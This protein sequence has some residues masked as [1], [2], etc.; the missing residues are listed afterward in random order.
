MRTLYSPEQIAEAI[1]ADE[2]IDDWKPW[3]PL[4]GPQSRCIVT[5]ADETFYGGQAGGSKTNTL[6][7]LALYHHRRSTIFRKTFL[8]LD[9]IIDQIRS[10]GGPSVKVS[11]TK[12]RAVTADG[13]VI[14]LGYMQHEKDKQKYKGRPSDF[15]GIDEAPDFTQSQVDFVTSWV[16]TTNP[17][18][19]TRV[20]LT[21]NPPTTLEGLW[22]I[23]AFAPWLKE[24][25]PDPAEPGELRWYSMIDGK[26]K[27]FRTGEPFEYTD[28]R[29]GRVDVIVPKSRTF[30]P[31]GLKDNPYLSSDRRYVAVLQGKPEPLRSQMLYGDFTIGLQDDAWQVIPTAWIRAA[32]ERWKED[33]RGE[34]PLTRSGVDCAY[35][36][37]D[38]VVL[39]RRYGDWIAPLTVWTSA[40]IIPPGSD[41]KA[42]GKAT[43]ALILPLAGNAS[44]PINV[45]VIGYGAATYEALERPGMTVNAVNFGEGANRLRDARGVLEFG[46]IRAFAYWTLR[47]ALDPDLN[48]NLALPPDDDLRAELAAARY[49]LRDGRIYLRSKEEV[50]AELG[51][52]PDLGDACVLCAFEVPGPMLMLLGD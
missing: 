8:E 22:I 27:W 9:E 38:R 34:C 26:L 29:S 32:Q 47:D 3:E 51:R 48:S 19:R 24:G 42:F 45:D 37:S 46:N 36:G 4:P 20:V 41:E 35:G 23:E 18:Q 1:Q 7:G 10:V 28:K 44:A 40:D 14:K 50:T 33:G 43:A 5:D 52:S 12:G 13:R 39:A 2:S 31:A 25:F 16:R 11:E 6:V 30:I 21:G 49:E 15:V 17:K